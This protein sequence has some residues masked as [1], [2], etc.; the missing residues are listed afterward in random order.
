MR[1]LHSG[2]ERVD[3][4]RSRSKRNPLNFVVVGGGPTR[5]EMA[6]TIRDMVTRLLDRK[7]RHLRREMAKVALASGNGESS[8]AILPMSPAESTSRPPRQRG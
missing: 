7:Y 4:E 6:G 5:V 1:K 8:A 2:F 3:G